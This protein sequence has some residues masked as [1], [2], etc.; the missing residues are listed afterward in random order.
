MKR[1]GT[2]LSTITAITATAVDIVIE[3]IAQWEPTACCRKIVRVRGRKM[4]P[5]LK[6][7]DI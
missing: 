3:R 1:G 4:P 2:G 7:I 5:P 6:A